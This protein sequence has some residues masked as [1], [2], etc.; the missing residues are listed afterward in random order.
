MVVT[1]S[2]L[3]LE[4]IP[5]TVAIALSPFPLVPV[6]LL[7][8]TARPLANGGGFLAGWFGGLAVLAAVFTVVAGAVE[9]WDEAPTWAAWTRLVLG[10][11]LI[12]LGVRTW[13]ARG[14]SAEVPAWMA[15]IGEYTPLRS[16]R[17]GVLLAVANPKSLL[18]VV[19]GGVAI[20]SAELGPGPSAVAV[21]LFAAGAASMVALPVVLRLVMGERIVGPLGVARGWL[22]AHNDAV[23]A[24]VVVLIGVMVASNGWS[25]L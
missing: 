20:G 1:V 2:D 11:V 15:A 8:L 14:G 10:V 23:V 21:L 22:V 6:V 7:L 13:L 19:A 25:E 4:L 12:A 17:L 16:V 18:L 5:L 3:A 9:L 24:V